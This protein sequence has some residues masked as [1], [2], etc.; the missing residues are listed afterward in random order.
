[1]KI[2]LLDTEA[3]QLIKAA[4]IYMTGHSDSLSDKDRESITKAN[5][6]LRRGVEVSRVIGMAKDLLELF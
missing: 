1:M 5:A 3:E 4:I 2:I 6:V